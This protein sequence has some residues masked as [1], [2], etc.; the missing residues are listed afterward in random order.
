MT[1]GDHIRARRLDLSLFQ[2]DVAK[3]IGVTTD[4]ITNWE[5]GRSSPDLRAIP[6]VLEFLGYDPRTEGQ[7]LGERLRRHRQ[8]LGIPQA[9]SARTM[10]VDPSTLAKWERGERTPR[11]PYLERVLLLLG[12]S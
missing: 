8:A 10:G 7:T 6:N 1:I 3:R 11:E 2:K 4:T 5:K 12:S 9:E